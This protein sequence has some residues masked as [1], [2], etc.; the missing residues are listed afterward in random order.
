MTV[1]HTVEALAPAKINLALHVTGQ[2]DDGYHLLDS[3]VGFTQLGD[4]LTLTA[5]GQ[6]ELSVSGP[7]GRDVPTDGSN[8]ICKVAEQAWPE[9]RVSF[10]LHKELPVAS[11]IGGGSADAA[12]CY[13][14]IA[15]LR[16]LKSERESLSYLSDEKIAALASLG[17]DIPMCVH[18][19]PAVV[20]GIGEDI[21]SVTDLPSLPILLVNPGIAVS[22]PAVFN[23]LVEKSN[24][25]MEPL[26]VAPGREAFLDWLGRQRNDL[27]A[28]ACTLVPVIDEVL[29]CL[30][31]AQ[32]CALA[33]MSGSGATCF[34]LFRASKEA[35][36][37]E[38]WIKEIN[39]S[40]WVQA[41]V[42]NGPPMSAPYRIRST[43]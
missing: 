14:A 36:Q 6:G 38:R 31:K 8:L 17:A 15:L 35:R 13:R 40:W 28:P 5:P 37:A 23:A 30:G 16:Q 42:I 4:T 19:M 34:G 10:H 21:R 18:S 7:F 20:R 25:A 24:T 1:P 27:Q 29:A 9:I 11:G 2:R 33:R 39:P 3:L 43:T 12:A 32:G 26:A 41:S 22:T